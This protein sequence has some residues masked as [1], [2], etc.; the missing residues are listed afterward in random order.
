MKIQI[1]K[2]EVHVLD[3]GTFKL[4]GGA[5]FGVVPKTIWNKTNPADE[6]NRITLGLRPALVVGEGRKILIDAG[7]GDKFD[8]KWSAIY[9]VD[10]KGKSLLEE[11]SKLGFTPDDISDI[12]VT[13]LHFDHCGGFTA[14]INGASTLLFKNAD[15][16]VQKDHRQAAVK[17]TER[18]RASFLKDNLEP[19][20]SS[21]RLKLLNG[22]A[23]NVFEGISLRAV[24]GHTRAMQAVV[25]E[26]ED[27]SAYYLSD[28]APTTSH[29]P[30]PFI[31]GY[32]LFPLTIIEEK[33]TFFDEMIKKDAV[34]I[35]EHDHQSPL[36][37]IAKN[38]KGYFAVKL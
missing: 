37:K 22:D 16:Y 8:E 14:F 3:C 35:F 27:K 4:D 34:A 30:I 29:V 33:K 15:I 1:G 31:M 38:E 26:S 23:A 5:M 20:L 25:I 19:V 11:L 2:Y 18:D 12:I 32:D 21:P 9:G 13:H 7:I 24:N 10:N 36:A 17:P 6:L 28:L